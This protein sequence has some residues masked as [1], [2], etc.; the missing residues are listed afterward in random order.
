MAGK[1]S[2]LTACILL[3]ARAMRDV[4]RLTTL[5]TGGLKSALTPMQDDGFVAVSSPDSR[6]TMS[7]ERFSRMP[8]TRAAFY[9]LS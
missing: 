1:H 7:F 4:I 3:I 9:L 6:I 8:A 2:S 5:L